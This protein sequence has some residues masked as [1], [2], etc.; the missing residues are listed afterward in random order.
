MERKKKVDIDHNIYTT[1]WNFG[2]SKENT[3]IQQG[4][5]QSIKSKQ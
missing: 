1:I 2:V 3:F 5:I 4:H